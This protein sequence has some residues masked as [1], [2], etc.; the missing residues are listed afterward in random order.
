MSY[1]QLKN[2]SK[3]YTDGSSGKTEVLSNIN[4]EIE[5]GEFIAIVGFTGS[6]KT[7]LINLIAGLIEP[8][9]GEVTL[10]GQII[11]GPGPERGV[12][13]SYTHLTLP[14]IYSV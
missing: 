12:T 9:E 11:D 7:T 6:G 1:L 2:V 3:S 8:D 10:D 14:T 4:L 5:E 13:V